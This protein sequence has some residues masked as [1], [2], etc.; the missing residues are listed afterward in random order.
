MNTTVYF[1]IR[2]Q[3][4]N[5]VIC[6][7]K[8]ILFHRTNV[9]DIDIN[10]NNNKKISLWLYLALVLLALHSIHKKAFKNTDD[11]TKVLQYK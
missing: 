11:Y 10:G 9:G 4:N 8:A 7:K 6:E 3:L 1:S 2:K 5:K